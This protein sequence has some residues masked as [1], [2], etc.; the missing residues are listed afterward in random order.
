MVMAGELVDNKFVTL[1]LFVVVN[2]VPGDAKQLECEVNQYHYRP[3]DH[4]FWVSFCYIINYLL[5]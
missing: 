1:N 2:E 3:G 5:R 4:L